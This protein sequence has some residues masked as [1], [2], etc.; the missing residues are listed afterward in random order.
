MQRDPYQLL[1]RP[2]K[3][4]ITCPGGIALGFGPGPGLR[5]AIFWNRIGSLF[6]SWRPAVAVLD[7]FDA[8]RPNQPAALRRRFSRWEPNLVTDRDS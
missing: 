8:R 1:V 7:V 2:D 5:H 4:T 6:S 3:T